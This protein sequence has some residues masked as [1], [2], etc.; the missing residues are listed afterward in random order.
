MVASLEI[1]A[2]GSQ[3]PEPKMINGLLFSFVKHL[4]LMHDSS[5]RDH[6]AGDLPPQ[7]E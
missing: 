1:L 3:I 5:E 2:A 7:G 6:N 4:V